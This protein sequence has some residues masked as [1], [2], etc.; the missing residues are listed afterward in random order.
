M[1]NDENG[2]DGSSVIRDLVIRHSFVIGGAL[3]VHS[4]FYRPHTTWSAD[5]SQSV[6]GRESSD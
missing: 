1:T 2:A 5:R 4:S 3:V 6:A